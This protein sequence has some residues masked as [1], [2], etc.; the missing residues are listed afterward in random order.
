MKSI[1]QFI[2][3]TIINGLLFLV[4]CYGV[5]YLVRHI[6]QAMQHYSLRFVD[7]ILPVRVLGITLVSLIAL[8]CIVFFLGLLV[9]LFRIGHLSL[10]LERNLLKFLPFYN[11]YEK[12]LKKQVAA[13][14][15]IAK[16]PVL[17][18]T[19]FSQMPGFMIGEPLKDT[20]KVLVFYDGKSNGTLHLVSLASIVFP[21]VTEKDFEHVIKDPELTSLD[22]I[23]KRRES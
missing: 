17:I 18:H 20:A 3:E 10:W 14:H 1:F 8:L 2:K 22:K 23:L 4:P 13:S 5:F 19:G 16:T 15:N 11:V 6:W 12:Y 9:K 21:D 7:N